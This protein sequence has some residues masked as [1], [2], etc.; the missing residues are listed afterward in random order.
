MH[1]YPEI[2]SKLLIK[3]LVVI[4]GEVVKP[5]LKQADDSIGGKSGGNTYL[6]RCRAALSPRFSEPIGRLRTLYHGQ[7]NS[8]SV[9]KSHF[10]ERLKHAVFIEGFDAFCH[11]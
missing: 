11:G 5:T 4:F 9:F 8:L 7:L 3:V 6:T 10:G 2:L 1:P